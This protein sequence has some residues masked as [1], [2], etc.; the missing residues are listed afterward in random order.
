MFFSWPFASTLNMVNVVSYGTAAAEARE[1][2]KVGS[3]NPHA[4]VRLLPAAL[5]SGP[6][7]AQSAVR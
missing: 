2:H 6:C 1:Q 5:L 4:N 3:Q 7:G